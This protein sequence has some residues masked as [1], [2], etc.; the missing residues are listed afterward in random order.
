M[1]TRILWIIIALLVYYFSTPHFYVFVPVVF[2]TIFYNIAVIIL[3]LINQNQEQKQKKN[4]DFQYVAFIGV[5]AFVVSLF[6]EVDYIIGLFSLT[7]YLFLASFVVTMLSILIINRFYNL[8]Y[9]SL[10][11][12]VLGI[13]LGGTG[14]IVSIGLSVNNSWFASP[15]KTE[16]IVIIDKQEIRRR[17]SIKFNYYVWIETAYGNERFRVS[18]SIYNVVSFGDTLKFTIRKGI[19]G[20]D[21]IQ[22]IEM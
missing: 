19:L 9:K 7:N 4:K 17:R 3:S 22:K 15:S 2:I 14:L 13:I 16:K 8:Y 18:E 1:K 20:Y 5:G 11:Y 21:K 6:T 12:N 10:L